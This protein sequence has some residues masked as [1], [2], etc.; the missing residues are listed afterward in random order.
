V[1]VKDDK[2]IRTFRRW[3]SQFYSKN[4]KRESMGPN[5][6]APENEEPNVNNLENVSTICGG[7]KDCEW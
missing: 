2:D 7:E 5:Y 3:F 4:S 1:L 6:I